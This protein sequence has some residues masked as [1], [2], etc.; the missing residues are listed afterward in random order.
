MTHEGTWDIGGLDGGVACDPSWVVWGRG[1]RGLFVAAQDQ[2]ELEEPRHVDRETVGVLVSGDSLFS[3][4]GALLT[5]WSLPGLEMVRETELGGVCRQLS[6]EAA[7]LLVACGGAGV[8]RVEQGEITGHWSGHVSARHVAPGPDG[9]VLVAGWT[10]LV[11]LDGDM[12]WL[13]SQA[14]R[15][16]TMAVATLDDRIVVAE[17]NSPWLGTVPGGPSPEGRVSP[18]VVG[19]GSPTAIV[20]EGN[21]DLILENG[22]VLAPGQRV[23]WT[24]PESPGVV[25][26]GSNDPDEERLAVLVQ[27]SGVGQE[28]QNFIEQ[29]TEGSTWELQALR[30]EV[31][32][33][34][35]FQDG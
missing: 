31:I 24:L 16:A 2:G 29:D 19:V 17:W 34:G 23:T 35:L 3:V 22:V 13:G 27:A 7:E 26:L 1:K 5:E 20:N 12:E 33:L 11:V 30:G 4:G 10:E 25:T 32:W 18:A 6:G 8:Y 14:T 15:S 21:R 28:A 9:T